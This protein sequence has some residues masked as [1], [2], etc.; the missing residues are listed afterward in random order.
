MAE[1]KFQHTLQITMGS[2]DGEVT[3]GLIGCY[4]QLQFTQIPAIDISLYSYNGLA[5]LNQTP[6]KID[7]AKKEICRIFANNNL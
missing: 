7:N 3:C 4:L 1:E 5:V 6:Q 2:N